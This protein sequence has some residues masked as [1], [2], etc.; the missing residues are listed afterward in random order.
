MVIAA[1]GR[2][3]FWFDAYLKCNFTEIGPCHSIKNLPK[4]LKTALSFSH[5]RKHSLNPT[6][7]NYRANIRAMKKL[8][9]THILATTCC[10]SLREE[11]KPGDF[12]VLDSFIDRWVHLMLNLIPY[13]LV[14]LSSSSPAGLPNVTRSQVDQCR[15]FQMFSML[16]ADDIFIFPKS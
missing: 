16:N 13:C 3:T 7:V 9:V 14:T 2:C 11:M 4:T 8:G 10:G 1:N 12:V 5:G 15:R 6:E